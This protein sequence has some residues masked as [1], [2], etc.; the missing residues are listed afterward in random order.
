MRT[1]HTLL[2]LSG[3][4][5]GVA[6]TAA[7]CFDPYNDY[8]LPL[9][10]PKLATSGSGGMT[11]GTSTGG[12]GGGGSKPDC[13]GEPN[14]V[15]TVED[16]GVFVQAD[17]ADATG[18]GTRAKPY[19]TLQEALDKA[20]DKRVYACASAPFVEAVTISAGVE[21]FGGFACAKEWTWSQ[22]AKSMLNGPADQIALTL[23]SGAD[24][25]KV[26]NFAITA[27]SP[28]DM[29]MGGS[30]IAVVVADLAAT[31][32]HCDLIAGDAADGAKGTTPGDLVTP[33]QDAPMPVHGQMDA[34]VNPASVIGGP[35]GVTSCG[36]IDTSG[37]PGGKGGIT[38]AMNGSGQ[39]GGTGANPAMMPLPGADGLGGDGQVDAAGV[40]QPG[41]LGAPGTNGAPGG[42]GSASSDMLTPAG[43]SNGNDT[44]GKPGTPGQGGGGGGGAKSG[45]FCLGGVDGN[46]ASGGGGGAGGCG[47]K[48]GGGGK[49]GGSSVAL[50]SLGSK[51]TLV[52]VTLATGT[53]G[54]GGDGSLG[55]NGAK[56]GNGASGGSAA[57]LPPSIDG[58][59][60]GDGGKGGV[61]GSGGGGR[62]GHSI[63][64]AYAKSPAVPPKIKTFTHGMPGDGGAAGQGAP[65]SSNG[66]Q[67]TMGQCWDFGKNKSCSP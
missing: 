2:L 15:N 3:L 14:E 61:G 48:G 63:G 40:C 29:T 47:G 50:L 5:G 1:R 37:A 17:A 55:Q 36:A 45:L 57:A 24:G 66:A 46:G 65:M 53:G 59:K 33:G 52:E 30:S 22:G 44:D 16:C 23:V 49:A 41:H 26:E 11:T 35:P 27:A 62:G 58:C 9:T 43:I 7:G 6:S 39:S 20:G 31:F 18:D 32:D 10:D 54:K 60:G 13:S 64:L 51:L 4:L 34:C 21:L 67:G 12:N 25:A 28:S 19:K 8:Y 56:G 42:G 38:G